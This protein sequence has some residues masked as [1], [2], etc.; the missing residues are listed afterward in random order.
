M[1]IKGVG[2]IYVNCPINVSIISRK[3]TNLSK[4][5]MS[6]V[7][8]PTKNLQPFVSNYRSTTNTYDFY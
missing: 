4:N 7:H 2:R 6:E 8:F 3:S 5:A 1:D